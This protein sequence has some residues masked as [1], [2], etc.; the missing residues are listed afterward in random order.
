MSRNTRT[1]FAIAGLA[2]AAA[3]AGFCVV[4]HRAR[5]LP[6]EQDRAVAG[7]LRALHDL[8]RRAARLA[9]LRPL[10]P[11]VREFARQ[12]L[13]AAER[14]VRRTDRFVAMDEPFGAEVRVFAEQ[15]LQNLGE[16]EDADFNQAYAEAMVRS[17]QETLVW[18]NER[19][20]PGTWDR[21]VRHALEHARRHAVQ[22]LDQALQL[23]RNRPADVD[24]P[25]EPTDASATDPAGLHGKRRREALI[26]ES[27]EETFPA[28]DP[29]SPFIPAR[30]P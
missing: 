20:L 22:R 11:A 18:I 6:R 16:H 30:A 28:S 27:V 7:A 10:S 23:L 13:A 21:G 4:R 1:T 12:Q 14:G 26:D 5:S 8:Q 19:L 24:V 25:L 2:A 17:H 3:V 9:L 15:C 29:V